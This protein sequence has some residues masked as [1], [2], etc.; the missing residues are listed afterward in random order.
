LVLQ[1][2]NGCLP[3]AYWKPARGDLLDAMTNV[4][5]CDQVTADPLLREAT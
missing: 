1:S 4:N 3:A 2:F 5:T